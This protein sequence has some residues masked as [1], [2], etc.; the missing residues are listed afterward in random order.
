VRRKRRLRGLR[1][2]EHA[3]IRVAGPL[4][5]TGTAYYFLDNVAT[6]GATLQACRA[7]LGFGDGIVFAD[8]GR[9]LR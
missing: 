9:A 3:F 4:T 1:G 8:E 7:A 5:A 6:T 2:E